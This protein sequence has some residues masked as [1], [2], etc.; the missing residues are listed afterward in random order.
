M[1][2]GGE[3]DE[4][5]FHL[6]GHQFYVVGSNTFNKSLSR[7]EAEQLDAENKLVKRNLVNPLLKDTIRVPQFGV[8]VLRFFAKNPGKSYN[9]N[10]YYTHEIKYK[11]NDLLWSISLQS[12]PATSICCQ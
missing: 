7:N 5:I 9:N 8:V 11:K 3:Q 2:L 12:I 1:I 10:F 6:H 4:H